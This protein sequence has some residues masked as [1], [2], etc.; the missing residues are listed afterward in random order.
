MRVI[1]PGYHTTQGK[2]QTGQLT[3]HL[4]HSSG[5]TTSLNNGL[6]KSVLVV[7][8]GLDKLARTR[9]YRS[10]GEEPK[11]LDPLV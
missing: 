7:T 3:P 2:I 1:F 4:K 9:K 10:L 6:H 8:C 5:A 11:V